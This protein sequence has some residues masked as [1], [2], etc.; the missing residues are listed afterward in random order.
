MSN[1]WE[2]NAR[3]EIE[4]I[5]NDFRTRL[6]SV[7]RR[8]ADHTTDIDQFLCS[9]KLCDGPMPAHVRAE[10]FAPGVR[11]F[12]SRLE[13]LRS[14]QLPTAPTVCEI[15]VWKGAFSR[16]LLTHLSPASLHL[17]D[18]DFALLDPVVRED[19]AVQLHAGDSG[20]TIA[21]LLDDSIDFAY[22]DGDHSY[23][24]SRR[25]FLGIMPK[26]RQGAFIQAN[27]Y[28]PWSILSGF[29]Y[30]VMANVNE[31]LNQGALEVVGFAWHRFGHH[32][33]LLRKR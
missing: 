25:D 28:T 21:N 2:A 20:E 17:F 29:P 15:G 30:G 27:D 31:L 23:I 16:Q 7:R 14:A 9:T 3:E 10:A 4:Q 1:E 13:L 22:V 11:M 32:D 6:A 19:R 8:I 18:L 12:G 26:V 33:V 5:C 24:G